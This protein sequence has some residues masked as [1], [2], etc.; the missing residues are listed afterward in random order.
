M[1]K[2]KKYGFT[3]DDDNLI[4]L[5]ELDGERFVI[6]EISGL[7]VK[8]EA[9]KVSKTNER[10]HG[11]KYSFTLHDRSN[12]RIM[13]FDNAHAIENHSKKKTSFQRTYD[14][15]HEGVN[16]KPK[17]YKYENASKLLEDFWKEVDLIAKKYGN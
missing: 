9:K 4:N 5:L 15:K 12:I 3:I 14:H 16:N 17:P 7:W 1:S 2:D 8:F 13:G 11:I 6:S 10:P